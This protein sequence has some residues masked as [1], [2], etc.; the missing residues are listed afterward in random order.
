MMTNKQ[1]I[2]LQQKEIRTILSTATS[3]VSWEHFGK[4]QPIAQSEVYFTVN[5]TGL[6]DVLLKTQTG[7]FTLLVGI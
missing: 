6:P 3:Q 4:H 7:G 2:N 5:F 1:K